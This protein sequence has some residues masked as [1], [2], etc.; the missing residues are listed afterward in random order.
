MGNI[1]KILMRKPVTDEKEHARIMWRQVARIGSRWNW[2][3]YK[4]TMGFSISSTEPSSSVVNVGYNFT[5]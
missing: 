1:Y 3:G 5:C 2:L 4:P